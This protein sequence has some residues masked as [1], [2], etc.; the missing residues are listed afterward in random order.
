ME[1]EQETYNQQEQ[2]SIENENEMNHLEMNENETKEENQIKLQ[3]YLHV[4]QTHL[5]GVFASFINSIDSS[6]IFSSDELNSF[7]NQMNLNNSNELNEIDENKEKEMNSL[8][9]MNLMEKDIQW[10]IEN[11]NNEM[12]IYSSLFGVYNKYISWIYNQTE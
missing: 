6:C 8:S 4:K 11:Y 5:S 3:E 9:F 1:T 10:T 2:I 7:L 12:N